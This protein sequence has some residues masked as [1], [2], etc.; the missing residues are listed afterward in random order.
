MRSIQS[1]KLPNRFKFGLTAWMLLQ[2]GRLIA[3][4]LIQAVLSGKDSPVWMYPAILD[5]VV[6]AATPILIYALWRYP[7]PKTWL[8]CWTYLIVSII[9]HGG[10]ITSTLVVGMP[11]TFQEMFHLANDETFKGIMT[12]PGGQTIIDLLFLTL[13]VRYRA[14]FLQPN[15]IQTVRQ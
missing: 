13:L 7:T 15:M 11:H 10:A 5:V 2:L 12:G 8:A 1:Q 14:I 6:A 9:D 3:I 4:P